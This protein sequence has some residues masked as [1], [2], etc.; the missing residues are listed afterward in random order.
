MRAYVFAGLG[1]LL[2]SRRAE[3]A[4]P[5][6]ERAVR[7]LFVTLGLTLKGYLLHGDRLGTAIS[8]TELS[9]ELQRFAI[10]YL[11]PSAISR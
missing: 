8:W 7:F 9:D 5:D 11:V 1:Q 4:H 10:G 3:I 6:P 2:L